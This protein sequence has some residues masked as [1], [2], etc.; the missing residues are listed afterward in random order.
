MHDKTPLAVFELLISNSLSKTF[1]QIIASKDEIHYSISMNFSGEYDISSSIA[2]RVAKQAKLSPKLIAEKIILDIDNSSF[3]SEITSSNGY[4]NAKLSLK[5]F[6]SYV[7][8]EVLAKKEVYGSSSMGKGKRVLIEYPSVNPN[9]PWHIGHVRNPLLGDSLA[10]ILSFCSYTVLRM[11]YIEDLGLQMAEILWGKKHLGWDYKGKKFDQ[12]LGEKYVEINKH[13]KDEGVLEEINSLL[14]KMENTKSIEAKEIREI[15][16]QSVTAQ[17]ETAFKYGLFH[18]LLVWESDILNEKLLEKTME[19]LKEK[20]LLR[21]VQQGKLAG[22][23]VIS[24]GQQ[25]ENKQHNENEKQQEIEEQNEKV[26]LRSNGVPTYLAKDIALHMWKL[27][28]LSVEFKQTQFI[29]QPDGTFALTTNNIG[30]DLQFKGS[31]IAINIIGSAQNEPQA[32]LRKTIAAIDSRKLESL[33]HVSYGEV[34]L[35]EG[36]ISGRSGTWLGT[37]RNYTADDLL[38]TVATK[39]REILLSS[40]KLS[41]DVNHEQISYQTALSAIKFDFLRIDP[42]KKLVFD[43]DRAL[44]FNS[45]SGPYC[46]Y[47][48]ARA[49]KILDKGRVLK[50]TKLTEKDISHIERDQSFELLKYISLCGSIVEKACVEYKPNIIAE[51]VMELSILFGKFYESMDVLKAGEARQLR[52]AI[53]YATKQTLYNMLMLLGIEPLASM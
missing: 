31:D 49:C 23:T 45:N 11:D 32:V 47:M 13:L 10:R 46:M 12:F 5:V 50:T 16:T 20:K 7:L 28:I 26:L 30:S 2:L 25:N 27:G 8:N 52:L 51:Y 29:K 24:I 42:I 9:K 38:K 1:P 37:E 4:I 39:A 19:L 22:C 6:S 3:F 21:Q 33:V 35:K 41:P 18:D 15:A 34:S 43:W 17:Y 36:K 40:D 44:D 14:K 48:Y 53:V